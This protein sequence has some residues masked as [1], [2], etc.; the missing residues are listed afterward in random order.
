MTAIAISRHVDAPADRVWEVL[1]DIERSPETIRAIDAVEVHTGPGFDVGTRWTETRTM[2]GRTVSETMEV[3]ELEPGRS[4]VV[5]ATSGR[6]HYRSEFGVAP[7]GQGTVVTMTFAGEPSGI[8]GKIM[9]ATLGRLFVGQTRKAL[10]QD[11]EDIA[12]ASE[13]RS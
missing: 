5:E 6:T 9:V 1:T 10:A 12:R 7:D 8:G 3:T 13:Q 2:M 11:L 4:Y